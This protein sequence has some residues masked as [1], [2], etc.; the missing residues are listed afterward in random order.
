MSQIQVL[1][2]DVAIYVI[3]N[4]TNRTVMLSDL[5]AEIKPRGLL[6][7]ERVAS[8]VAIESSKD[9]QAALRAKILHLGRHSVIRTKSN[10][11]T[12][13]TKSTVKVV[14]KERDLDEHKLAQMVRQALKDGEKPASDVDVQAQVKEAV[15]EGIDGLLS[16][17]RDQIN[18]IQPVVQ[19]QHQSDNLEI[20]PE[21]FA[22]ISQNAVEKISQEIETGRAKL[23]KKYKINK[24]LRDL[25]DGL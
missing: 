15:K 11:E 7:L 25:A 1:G 3:H 4:T 16:S 13:H 18:S 14:E 23:G 17:I 8:R 22:E 19:S 2:G 24:N 12:I 5:R 20:D 9:L 21:K 6:D 10:P